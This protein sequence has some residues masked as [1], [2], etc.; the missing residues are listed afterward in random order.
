MKHV[1]TFSCSPDDEGNFPE[2][3]SSFKKA[4]Y[5]FNDEY[6]FVV[7]R[8]KIIEVSRSDGKIAASWTEGKGSTQE[9]QFSILLE[10]ISVS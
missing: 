9:T 8:G 2:L 7:A 5:R 3:Y 6:E 1:W 10:K 4:L